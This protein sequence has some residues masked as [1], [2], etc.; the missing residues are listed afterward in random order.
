MQAT[1]N[2]FSLS[3]LRVSGPD[4]R[5]FLQSQLTS[6]VESTGDAL[7]PT[8]WCNP[9]GRV[10]AVMLVAGRDESLDL[11]LPEPVAGGVLKRLGMFRIG[12]RVD[13]EAV[14]NAQPA[15][16]EAPGA[17]RLSFDP[18]RALRISG[19][20]RSMLPSSWLREDIGHSLPWV[21]PPVQARFLP[22]M[23]GLD[24]LG[25]LSYRKGCFPGQE[26]IARVHYRGRVTQR[27]ARVTVDEPAARPGA[28]I[29][30]AAGTGTILYAV[31]ESD[32]GDRRAAGD[33]KSYEALAVVP[34]DA[35]PGDEITGDCG[36]GVLVT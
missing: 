32:R 14:G 6:N 24:T 12:R 3:V 17:I 7:Q 29:R 20:D 36:I 18:E 28:E 9:K 21:L 13:L 16:P 15:A 25:G 35:A 27:T 22:Q 26:V 4:A 8:A 33:H 23:L 2:A 11:L 34:S 30:L 19:D 5:I 31:P 10:E 1:E